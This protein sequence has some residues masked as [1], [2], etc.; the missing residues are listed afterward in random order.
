MSDFDSWKNSSYFYLVW[1]HPI[2][3]CA[4]TPPESCTRESIS[5]DNGWGGI[6]RINQN[7][8]KTFITHPWEESHSLSRPGTAL[9]P[10]LIFIKHVPCRILLTIMISTPP[11]LFIIQSIKCIS[12][13]SR[14]F[15]ASTIKIISNS[16]RTALRKSNHPIKFIFN[17]RNTILHRNIVTH[18]D[19]ARRTLDA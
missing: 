17:R 7:A 16:G 19:G 9:L 13:D 1:R 5:G 6:H 18:C 11:E 4:V 15:P 2:C 10:S 14:F 12:L 3:V 8:T